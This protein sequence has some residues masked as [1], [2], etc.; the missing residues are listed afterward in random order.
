[1]LIVT[2]PSILIGSVFG[3]TDESGRWKLGEYGDAC[4]GI[5][6]LADVKHYTFEKD[7]T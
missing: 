3:N 7:G 4:G 5:V 1:M 2:Y 6:S